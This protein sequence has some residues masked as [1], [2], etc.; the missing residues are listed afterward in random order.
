[1]GFGTTPNFFFRDKRYREVGY[2][3]SKAAVR[4]NVGTPF[5][6]DAQ[7]MEDYAYTAETLLRYGKVLINNY[8]FPVAGHYE[9]GGIGTYAERLPKK[10]EASEILMKRY[11]MLFR[12]PKKKGTD[13]KGELAIRFTSLKQVEQWRAFMR[14]KGFTGQPEVNK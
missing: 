1:M 11:P 2:V 9:K 8:I 7:A 3:I 13:P 4:K 10:I 6:L 14:A 12:H 5:A